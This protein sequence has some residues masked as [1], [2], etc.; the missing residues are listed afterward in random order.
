MAGDHFQSSGIEAAPQPASAFF[1]SPGGQWLKAVL[2]GLIYFACAQGGSLLSL[3]KDTYVGFWIPTGIY[4]AVLLLNERRAWPSLVLA[5]ATANAAFDALHGTPPIAILLFCLGNALH[6]VGSA[7]LIQRFISSRI[8]LSTLK[9]LGGL[10]FVGAI[11]GTAVGAAIGAAALVATGVSKSFLSSFRV[12]WGSCA[13]A[14]LIFTPFVLSWFSREKSTL[15]KNTPRIVEAGLLAAGTAFIILEARMHVEGVFT[16][17]KL[18][19]IPPLLWAG[20]RFGVRGAS[21]MVVTLAIVL[22]ILTARSLNVS[23]RVISGP[24]ESHVFMLQITLTISALV[25]LI[26]AVV[27]RERDRITADLRLSRERFELAMRGSNDGYWDWNILSNYIYF[28]DRYRE[29]LGYG[30]AE[31]APTFANFV[32]HLHPD[33]RDMVRLRIG[34]H[35]QG[36]EPYD[37]EY[38]MKTRSGEYRWFRGRGHAVWN[39]K[40]EAVRMAGALT[41]ITERKHAEAALRESEEKFATAF[42]ASPDVISITDLE[43]GRYLE[44]NEVHEKLFGLKR[45]DVIGRSPTELGIITDISQRDRMIEALRKNGSI[46][47]MEIRAN[48]HSGN[49]LILLLSAEMIQL[50]GRPCILRVSHDITESKRAQEALRESEERYRTVVEFSPEFIAI[51]IDRCTAYI[52]PAGVAMLGGKDASDFIGKPAFDFISPEQHHEFERR[53]KALFEHGV[54]TIGYETTLVRL[55]GKKIFCEASVVPI[56]YQGRPGTLALIR[57][58]TERKRTEESLRQSE[59]RFRSYFEL[60]IVGLAITSLEKGF[61]EVNDPFCKLLGYSREE[62]L[63]QRWSDLTYPEDLQKDTVLFNSV[64][65]GEQD[66]YTIEKRYLHRNGTPIDTALSVRCVRRADGSPDYFIS[67]VQDITQRKRAEAERTEALRREQQALEDYTRRLIES[68]EAERRRIAGELHDS[69]GQNL[70]LIHNR[71]QQALSHP[72]DGPAWEQLTAIGQLTSEAIAEV[73]NI[74][75]DLRPYQLDQLGLTYALHLLIDGVA[76]SSGLVIERKL[77]QADDAVNSEGAINLYRIVQETLTNILKHS[78][79]RKVRV[80]L[81]RDIHHLLL[82]ITD[83]GKG[84][85]ADGFNPATSK[86][87]LG[88]RNIFERVRILGGTLKIHSAPG[89]GTSLEVTV[90]IPESPLEQ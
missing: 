64:L 73:R 59:K 19:I 27:L 90:P 60:P 22:S 42:R 47:D 52:N 76:K 32:A 74:S 65:A 71:V 51:T 72:I 58:I 75:R 9:E 33:D 28:S 40:G 85:P 5:A 84:F 26:P 80:Q 2:F 13:M 43:T 36:R 69:L 68:Q 1:N 14:V 66:G 44:V 62:L 18:W 4:L 20:L 41:D 81:E 17:Y 46:R 7:L 77:D 70:L 6:A 24:I 25:G 61:L 23:D 88:L 34:S 12:W 38:R 78:E 63:Q 37:L 21:A 56:M 3:Q 53:R 79:A 8:T 48:D 86:G 54:P 15:L 29:L 50:N 49:E 35:L 45:E 57:D 11:V 10:L 87:G 31:F 30:A 16:P 89:Q 82:W 67:L 83:D 39:E 55:D